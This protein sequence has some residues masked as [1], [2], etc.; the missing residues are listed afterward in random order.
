MQEPKRVRLR[1]EAASLGR[2]LG[3]VLLFR[4]FVAQA[5]Y[6][7]SESMRPTLE[8]GDRIVVNRLAYKLD[9]PT[10]GDVVVF[11]HPQKHGTDMVKRVVATGG[12]WV[13]GRDGKVW[14]NGE[15]R[16]P[17]FDFPAMQ[18]P[19]DNL[20]MLGDNRDNSSDSRFWGFVPLGL[21]EG[22]AVAIWWSGHGAARWMSVIR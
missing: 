19:A 12:D 13:E 4:A 8:V 10:R 18:V 16:G 17:S 7:P 11:D 9:G 14:V 3:L 1:R 20:F 2:L 6:I 22:R 21:V 5:Y 15:P